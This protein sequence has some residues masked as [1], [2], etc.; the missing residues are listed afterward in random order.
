M[1]ASKVCLCRSAVDRRCHHQR[2]V[3]HKRIVGT[4]L[5]IQRPATTRIRC[6]ARV[7]A[8]AG[9]KGDRCGRTDQTLGSTEARAENCRQ[10]ATHNSLPSGKRL[11]WVYTSP[12][13]DATRHRCERAELRRSGPVPVPISKSAEV[14]R[15][16]RRARGLRRGRGTRAAFRARALRGIGHVVQAASSLGNGPAQRR[17]HREGR[18]DVVNGQVM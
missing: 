7:E 6:Q 12:C 14:R 2:A 18:R 3:R 10:S 9:A 4:P 13:T 15:R 17:V 16:T 5:F 11:E 8:R 1:P